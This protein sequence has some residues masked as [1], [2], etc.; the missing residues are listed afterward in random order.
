LIAV[1]DL[2]KVLCGADG[3]RK[4]VERVGATLS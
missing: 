4:L 2:A 3:V 1:S